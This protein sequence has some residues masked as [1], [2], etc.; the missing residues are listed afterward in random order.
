M[1]EPFLTE[2]VKDEL[3]KS[4][5]HLV[6]DVEVLVFTKKGE[7]DQY[8]ELATQLIKEFASVDKRIKAKFHK[9]GDEVANKHDVTRSPTTLI[10]PDKY[11]M[12]FTG[13]PLGEEGRSLVLA[14]IM[15][16]NGISMMDEA[17]LKRLQDLK[18]KRHVQIFFSPT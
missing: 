3:R 6:D 5:E 7:N 11:K 16:S 13:T 4:F 8:N 15:A 12:R 18:E 1:A 9:I 17:S 14:L 2:D 10:A